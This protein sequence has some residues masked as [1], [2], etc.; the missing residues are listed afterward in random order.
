MVSSSFE[1]RIVIKKLYIYTLGHKVRVQF[2]G[3]SVEITGTPVEVT[4]RKNAK[5][6]LLW[7]Q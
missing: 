1:V 3:T 2:Y 7:V 4:S 6:K 5:V